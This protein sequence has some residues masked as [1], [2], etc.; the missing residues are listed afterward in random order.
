MPRRSPQLLRTAAPTLWSHGSTC[1]LLVGDC[2]GQSPCSAVHAYLFVDGL[3]L[4]TRSN[5][6]AVGL[7]PR[8]LLRPGGPLCPTDTARRVRVASLDPSDPDADGL[9][10]RIRLRG[11]TVVWSELMFPGRK[12]QPVEE[13]RF[14]LGCYLAEIERG[15]ACA[16]LG[17]PP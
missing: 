2:G 1:T 8:Q 14:H 5:S 4:I 11:E 10:I 15:Y 7:H 3:D 17:G 12:L 16:G 9:D 6:G 13:V